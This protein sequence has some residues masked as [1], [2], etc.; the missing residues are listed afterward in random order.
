MGAPQ[1][2]LPELKMLL[3]LAKSPPTFQDDLENYLERLTSTEFDELNERE[4]YNYH[5][6]RTIAYQITI[7]QRNIG[8]ILKK[9]PYSSLT[10]PEGIVS[11]QILDS[12]LEVEETVSPQPYTIKSYLETIVFEGKPGNVFNRWLDQLRKMKRDCEEDK[13]DIIPKGYKRNIDNNIV[14]LENV[15][16]NPDLLKSLPYVFCGQKQQHGT[17]MVV[18]ERDSFKLMAYRNSGMNRNFTSWDDSEIMKNQMDYFDK[19]LGE[20][21][22]IRKRVVE[23]GIPPFLVVYSDLEFKTY[24]LLHTKSFLDL[25]DK[26]GLDYKEMH[27]DELKLVSWKKE[28]I[29]K[30]EQAILQ[31]MNEVGY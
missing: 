30:E 26:K 14:V 31:D 21:G 10:K 18:K 15:I 4:Q 2:I 29:R 8:D 7:E 24:I 17:V 6:L 9:V 12:L 27:P 13:F 25:C 23:E 5:R 11:P 3:E 16:A 22:L 1:S 28:Q 20:E 19:L